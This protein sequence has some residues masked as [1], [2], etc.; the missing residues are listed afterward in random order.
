MMGAEIDW[1]AL[2]IVCEVFGI[3]DVEEMIACLVVIRDREAE[4]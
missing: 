4:Q 1:T 3:R 2:P